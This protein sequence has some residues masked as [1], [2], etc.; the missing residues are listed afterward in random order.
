MFK[1]DSLLGV[2]LKRT[3]NR[4]HHKS[5]YEREMAKAERALEFAERSVKEGSLIKAAEKYELA[6]RHIRRAHDCI[7]DYVF[8]KAPPNWGATPAAK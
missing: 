8:D 2:A 1:I 4:A 3:P 5:S 6:A 7:S